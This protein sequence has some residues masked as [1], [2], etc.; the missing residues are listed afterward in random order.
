ME[1]TPKKIIELRTN[2]HINSDQG[3]DYNLYEVG[4]RGV[5]RITEH[6]PRGEGDRL[7][8]D[9]HKTGGTT[10][11]LYNP[12]CVTTVHDVPVQS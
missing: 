2:W 12:D 11:R 9:V 8:Y 10:L 1:T 5:E 3:E 7:Y 4:K 6:L